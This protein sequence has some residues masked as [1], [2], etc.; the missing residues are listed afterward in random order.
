MKYKIIPEKVI[1]VLVEFLDRIQIK[2]VD[3][4][5]DKILHFCQ[6]IIIIFYHIVSNLNLNQF[7]YLLY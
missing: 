1:E 3:E 4:Q 6:Y 2:A 5:D 7:Q